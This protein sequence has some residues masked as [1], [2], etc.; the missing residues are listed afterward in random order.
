MKE[1]GM[2]DLEEIL[3]SATQEDNPTP[4]VGRL[5]SI[6]EIDDVAGASYASCDDPEGYTQSGGSYTQDGGYYSQTGGS[7]TMECGC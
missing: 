3:C 1:T 2:R 5:L 4:L 7:Y 6:E